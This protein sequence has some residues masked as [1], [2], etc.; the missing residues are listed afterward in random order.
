M[1]KMKLCRFDEMNPADDLKTDEDIALYLNEA[2]K[3]DDPNI[4]QAAMRDIARAK[5]MT[6]IAEKSGISREALYRALRENSR[7][8]FNTVFQVLKAFG[9]RLRVEIAP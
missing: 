4:L 1:R 5:G 2:L 7:P 9:L 8:E 3:Y 6:S